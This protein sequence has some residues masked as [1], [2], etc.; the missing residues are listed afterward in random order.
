ML[1]IYFSV[2]DIGP[3]FQLKIETHDRSSV[4]Y[5]NSYWI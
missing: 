4:V 5:D 2:N 3:I 1:D